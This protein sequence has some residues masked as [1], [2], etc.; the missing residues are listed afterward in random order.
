MAR[1]RPTLRIRLESAA[2][3]FWFHMK[4]FKVDREEFMYYSFLKRISYLRTVLLQDDETLCIWCN[5]ADAV[6]FARFGR[7]VEGAI[8]RT[9]PVSCT[10][11]YIAVQH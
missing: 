9:H 5:Y 8:A 1:V 4:E 7:G 11:A 10:T 2:L 6:H 3:D